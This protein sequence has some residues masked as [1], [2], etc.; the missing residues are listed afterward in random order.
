MYKWHKI[1]TDHVLNE[2][3]IDYIVNVL[4]SWVDI[5]LAKTN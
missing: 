2:N 3:E 5:E 1:E 4:M